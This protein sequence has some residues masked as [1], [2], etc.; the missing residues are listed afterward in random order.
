L[1]SSTWNFPTYQCIDNLSV[2]SVTRATGGNIFTVGPAH[3]TTQPFSDTITGVFSIFIRSGWTNQ[4]NATDQ[5]GIF[6]IGFSGASTSTLYIVFSLAST[7]PAVTFFI[8]DGGGSP[9]RYHFRVGDEDGINWLQDDKWYQIAFSASSSGVS[10]AVNGSTTPIVI[11]TA[12][13]AGDINLDSGNERIWAVGGPTAAWGTNNPTTIN[14]P[15]WSSL[16][17]GPSCWSTQGLDFSSS[18]VRARIWDDNGDFKNPG[19]DGS[20][21]F[22]DTYA[23]NTPEYYFVDGSP[24]IQHGSDTQ[25]WTNATGIALTGVNA[26][27]RKQYE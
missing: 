19:E 23:A 3:S 26:G 7:N 11:T 18:A 25:V 16:L 17:M 14:S 6:S 13:V 20:L 12:D 8:S 5:Q 10:Y 15:V 1:S 9:T 21:W 22:G 4:N 2:S 27:L 24:I